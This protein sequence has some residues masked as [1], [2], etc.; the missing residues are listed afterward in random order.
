[1]LLNDPFVLSD[2]GSCIM[3]IMPEVLVLILELVLCP[4]NQM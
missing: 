4:E 2:F 3:I 1:M